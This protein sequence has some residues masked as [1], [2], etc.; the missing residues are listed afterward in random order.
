MQAEGPR[1]KMHDGLITQLFIAENPKV[2]KCAY[3]R[4]CGDF[5]DDE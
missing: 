2:T 3:E 4:Y 1:V 5:E